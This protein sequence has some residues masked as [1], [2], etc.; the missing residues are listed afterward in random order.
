[1]RYALSLLYLFSAY[2]GYRPGL[3]DKAMLLL[4]TFLMGGMMLFLLDLSEEH[5]VLKKWLDRWF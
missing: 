4:Y 5:P 3:N 1:M 2:I